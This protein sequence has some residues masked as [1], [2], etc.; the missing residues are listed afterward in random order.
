MK[1]ERRTTDYLPPGTTLRPLRNG[2]VVKVLPLPLS[3]IIH[4]DWKGSAVRG[5]ITA[6]GKGKYPN[7]YRTGR[8]DGKD[9]RTVR[10][11]RHF[12]PTEAQVGDIVS[13]GGMENGGYG[14]T[15]IWIGADEHVLATEDD[16]CAI[17]S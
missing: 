11:S 6:I 12:R 7:L 13:L 10:S 16:I 4:A 15:R 17:E 14:F 2:I 3:D 1:V 8:Q 5:E 9:F